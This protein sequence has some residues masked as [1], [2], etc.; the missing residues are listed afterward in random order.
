[1]K[2]VGV[3]P[4]LKSPH[5]VPRSSHEH[6]E[7]Y[8][9]HLRSLLARDRQASQPPLVAGMEKLGYKIDRFYLAKP[10]EEIRSE[11]IRRA[12]RRTLN[13]SLALFEDTMS[14]VVKLAWAI[15]SAP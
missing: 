4:T 3:P 11:Q 14:Q 8:K 5:F 12:D 13:L 6:K 15:A 7:L 10:V 2:D 1:M 9:S